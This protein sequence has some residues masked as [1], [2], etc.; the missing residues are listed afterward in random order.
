[1]AGAPLTPVSLRRPIKPAARLSKP[2]VPG[3][4]S[5]RYWSEAELQVLR[6]H[7]ETKGPQYC[8]GLLANR[9]TGSIYQ[10]PASWA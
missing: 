5:E 6:D 10:R 8:R 4:H 9:S 2:Y 1:M 7:F 3:R